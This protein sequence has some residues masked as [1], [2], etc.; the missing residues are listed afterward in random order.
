M[1]GTIIDL[2]EHLTAGAKKRLQIIGIAFVGIGD[3]ASLN[4][5]FWG[6]AVQKGIGAL[7]GEDFQKFTSLLTK[8]I[9]RRGH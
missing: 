1:E 8:T 9:D 2:S 5:R 7:P 3:D 4:P 6:L